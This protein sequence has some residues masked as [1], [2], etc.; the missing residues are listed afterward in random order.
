[1]SFYSI[2]SGSFNEMVMEIGEGERE[3]NGIPLRR[4]PRAIIPNYDSITSS[5]NRERNVV[6][7]STII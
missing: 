6:V 1:M 4:S 7:A 2:L 5:A 3:E